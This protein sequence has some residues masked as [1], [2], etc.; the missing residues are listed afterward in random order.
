MR[1]LVKWP[2]FCYRRIVNLLPHPAKRLPHFVAAVRNAL[3][4]ELNVEYLHFGMQP[5][6]LHIDKTKKSSSDE[7]F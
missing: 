6:S 5:N 7:L 4:I 3:T 2:L 1:Q